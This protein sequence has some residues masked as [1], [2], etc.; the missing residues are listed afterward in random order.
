MTNEAADTYHP[1]D[2]ENDMEDL[3]GKVSDQVVS[4]E[5]PESVRT[6]GCGK[7]RRIV[8]EGEINLEKSTKPLR[9]CR[10]CGEYV[11]HD[12]RNCPLNKKNK[13]KQKKVP[14]IVPPTEDV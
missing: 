2:N 6:K 8:G 14:G 3:I 5:N 1:V 13:K 4:I 7:V 12:T 10:S 9:L 11:N